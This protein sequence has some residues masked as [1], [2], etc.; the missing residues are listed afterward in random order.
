MGDSK[1]K[2]SLP[3]NRPHSSNER[4]KG[5]FPRAEV[6]YRWGKGRMWTWSF[7]AWCVTVTKA[8]RSKGREAESNMSPAHWLGLA[9]FSGK[10]DEKELG[11]K[12]GNLISCCYRSGTQWDL[13][14]VHKH[15]QKN[16]SALNNK[17]AVLGNRN[18]NS[19]MGI[20]RGWVM[21]ELWAQGQITVHPSSLLTPCM[22]YVMILR[23]EWLSVTGVTAYRFPIDASP[24]I[25]CRQP[26]SAPLSPPMTPGEIFLSA[27]GMQCN[28]EPFRWNIHNLQHHMGAAPSI[29]YQNKFQ[30]V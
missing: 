8:K 12:K 13:T 20:T 1:V 2:R 22:V 17:D 14:V 5:H 26:S 16:C 18:E 11:T 23:A 24:S 6:W 29:N 28:K 10:V 15:L 9:I 3:V 21:V 19:S 4:E 25:Q 7:K 30:L 27:R